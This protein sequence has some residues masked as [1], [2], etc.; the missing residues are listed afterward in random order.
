MNYLLRHWRGEVRVWQAAWLSSLL[1]IAVSLPVNYLELRQ[2]V[3]GNHLSSVADLVDHVG[4]DGYVS[5]V[6]PSFGLQ[7]ADIL[8][9]IPSLIWWC[10]GS[11]RACDRDRAQSGRR[12]WGFKTGIVLSALYGLYEIYDFASSVI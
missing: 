1:A 6:L 5:L 2:F 8:I 7:L 10:V 9:E 3:V 11:W 12:R 4:P